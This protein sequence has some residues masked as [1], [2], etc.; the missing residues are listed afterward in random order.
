MR[1]LSM[2]TP[3]E[4]YANAGGRHVRSREIHLCPVSALFSPEDKNDFALFLTKVAAV[5]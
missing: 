2:Y 1:S 4:A 3:F 5:L